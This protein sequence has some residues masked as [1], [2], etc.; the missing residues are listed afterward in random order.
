MLRLPAV[1]EVLLAGMQSYSSIRR[2]PF[3]IDSTF[4]RLSQ[5]NLHYNLHTYNNTRLSNKQ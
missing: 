4:P 3:I 1:V 2:T 5:L